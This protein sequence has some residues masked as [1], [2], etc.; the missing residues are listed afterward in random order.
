VADN[1]IMRVMDA[2]MAFLGILLNGRVL[3]RFRLYGVAVNVVGN[4][5]SRKCGRG[6]NGGPG[7]MPTR[8]KYPL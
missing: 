2:I 6:K 4:A 3:G 8:S 7:R 5:A 1:V